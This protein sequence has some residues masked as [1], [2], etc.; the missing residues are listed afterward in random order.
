[1][2]KTLLLTL[3]MICSSEAYSQREMY[4]NKVNGSTDTVLVSEVKNITFSA[5][6]V[7]PI[8]QRTYTNVAYA[9]KSTKNMLDLYL[10]ETGEGPFPLI[11]M[12]H[13][14]AFKAGDKAME[15]TNAKYMI[16]KG[17]AV[18]SI[19]YRLSGEAIFP[20]QIHD[21]KA[22]IRYLRAN[23]AK[24]ALNPNKFATWGE[25]AGAGLAALAGTSAD[26]TTIEDLTMGN[27]GVSSRVQA[28]VDLFGP[29][30]FLTM[31]SQWTTL[32]VTNG[33]DHDG[34]SSPESQLVGGAI[35]TMQDAC[36]QYNPETYITM[37]DP[38]FFIQHG[39]VDVLIPYLQGKEFSERLIPIIGADKVV[40]ELL[41][42]AGHGTNHFFTTTNMDKITTFLDSYLK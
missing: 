3:L 18:A 32:G 30:N 1:M 7:T 39:S 25:S 13:G 9:D 34:A 38:A 8:T 17:Y 33:Q 37:D 6:T 5:S 11:I 26:V 40:F 35:Q 22:A 12:I 4:I 28:V 41:S 23:A 36:N 21:V 29:I 2:K 20:A 16:A 10:P 14:G 42:G 19:N 15:A 27:S 31:N 24:Y